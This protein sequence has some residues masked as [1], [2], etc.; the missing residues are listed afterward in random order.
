MAWLINLFKQKKQ[1]TD[2]GSAQ[3]KESG[4]ITTAPQTPFQGIP[5]EIRF[6]HYSDNNKS[7]AKMQRWY[8]A[9]D[10]FK[11]KNYQKAFP[12]IF[13]YIRDDA[14]DNLQFEA[15]D[16]CFSFTLYQGAKKVTGHCDGQNLKA[17]VCLAEMEVPSTPVMRRLL[18]LNYEL[19]YTRTALTGNENLCMIFESDLSS[20]NPLKVYHGLRELAT[21]ADKQDEHLNTDFPQLK[22]IRDG[23]IAPLGPDELEVKFSFF[24]KWIE[25]TL[26]YTATLNP[27]AFAGAIAYCYLVLAYRIDFL[28]VPSNH[29]LALTEKISRIYWENKD[30]D[31]L[32]GRNNRMREVILELQQV[33][34]ENFATSVYHSKN[35]F[36]LAGPPDADKLSSNYQSANKDTDWY[37]RNKYTQLAQTIN[38]YGVAYNQFAYSM[39]QV[40]TSLATI[41]YAVMQSAY[42][43]ALGLAHPFYEPADQ[44][45]NQPLL[46]RAVDEALDRFKDKYPHLNWQHDKIQYDTLYNFGISFTEQMAQ[47]NLELKR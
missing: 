12:A 27:D 21:K 40:L 1:K 4:S 32:V 13:D 23:Q 20:A 3:Q 45:F 22:V 39:P 35:T 41:Y 24:K 31:T 11:D 25:E 2:A 9:E 26:N 43:K 15:E 28:I 42:F 6:G 5:P 30:Q 37:I 29:L 10:F 14:A 7:Y 38:E 18:E 44:H 46:E 34:K 47:L 17:H 19:F 33:S 16:H 8:D 36:A